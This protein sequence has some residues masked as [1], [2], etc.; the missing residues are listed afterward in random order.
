MRL[1]GRLDVSP[2]RRGGGVTPAHTKQS[3]MSGASV[4]GEV[5]GIRLDMILYNL[6]KSPAL[7]L[8]FEPTGNR[9][10]RIYP[11]TYGW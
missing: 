7:Y 8:D 2:A 4:V 9:E 6:K 1:S 11:R 5:I 10:P 3:S